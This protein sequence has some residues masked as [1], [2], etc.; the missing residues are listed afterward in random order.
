MH[1]KL[2]TDSAIALFL[3]TFSSH[4]FAH[5]GRG[6]VSL[7]FIVCIQLMLV[8]PLLVNRNL[9]N[10]R[11]RGLSIYMALL[12]IAWF[13]FAMVLAPIS[14]KIGLIGDFLM[15]LMLTILPALAVAVICSGGLPNKRKQ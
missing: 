4:A 9:K 1:K 5:G 12:V 7:L 3:L 10:K 8:I 2:R 15:F 11:I 6:I 13:L 14:S